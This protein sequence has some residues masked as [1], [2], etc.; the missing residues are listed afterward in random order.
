MGAGAIATPNAWGQLEI[1][2]NWDP[3]VLGHPSEERTN[4]RFSLTLVIQAWSNIPSPSQS[5]VLYTSVLP[6]HPELGRLHGPMIG[7]G[8]GKVRIG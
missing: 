8:A 3:H 7:M 2:L 4:Q 1:G 5:T 6:V